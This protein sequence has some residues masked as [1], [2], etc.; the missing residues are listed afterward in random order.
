MFEIKVNARKDNGHRVMTCPLAS[1]ANKKRKIKVRQKSKAN[2]EE[3]IVCL[4]WCLMPLQPLR[5]YHGGQSASM[6]F[7]AFHTGTDTT[8]LSKATE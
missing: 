3:S 2:S 7:L 8:F 1:G 5:S 6:C 4:H